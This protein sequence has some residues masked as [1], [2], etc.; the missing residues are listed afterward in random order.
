MSYRIIKKVLI[1]LLRVIQKWFNINLKSMY[2]KLISLDIVDSLY[3]KLDICFQN[4]CY[5]NALINAPKVNK[6]S[7]SDVFLLKT[8]RREQQQKAFE[9]KRQIEDNEALTFGFGNNS[10]FSNG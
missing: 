9:L 3:S 1:N 10:K 4:I 2:I 6:L 7:Q 5:L 8:E